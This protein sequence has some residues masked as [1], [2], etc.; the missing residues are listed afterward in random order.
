MVYSGAVDLEKTMWRALILFWLA[1][2]APALG[3]G[4][5]KIKMPFAIMAISYFCVPLYCWYL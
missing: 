3:G 1:Y 2:I 4:E 5:C